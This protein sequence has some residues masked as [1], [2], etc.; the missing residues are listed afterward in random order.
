MADMGQ[1]SLPL[2]ISSPQPCDYLENEIAISLFISPDV[3]VDSS[4]YEYLLGVGFR[5][6]G[7]YVYRP[8]CEACQACKPSRLQTAQFNP[9]RSQQRV[10]SKN[11]DIEVRCVEATFNEVHYQLYLKYQESRHTGGSMASFD[12]KLYKG[13]LCKSLGES[14]FIES[15]LDDKLIA[16]AL[17]D[18]F[19]NALS[20]VYTFFDPDYS[21][22]SLG[23][24]S[25]LEQ[26]RLA[27]SI[28]KRFLY[29]GYYIAESQKMSYKQNFKPLEVL[30]D[31]KWVP[32]K[33][34]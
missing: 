1:R 2:Y 12:E 34:L 7:T 25:V 32:F 27:R 30:E 24:F 15:W 33:T 14:V 6:S 4:T 23:T 5:R 13:F 31:E 19:Q 11:K 3:K 18:I 10:V 28:N 20:A 17:T 9:S 16:V 26:I 22:R 8:H 21:D 29:L